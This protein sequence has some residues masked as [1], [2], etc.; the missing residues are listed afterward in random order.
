ML[1]KQEDCN[2]IGK[3]SLKSL[4][5]D[6]TYDSYDGVIIY[7]RIFEGELHIGQKIELHSNKKNYQVEKIGVNIPQKLLKNKLVAG[8]I[9]WFAANIRNMRDIKVGDTILN[10]QSTSNS[11]PGYQEI[12]PNVYANLY[13]SDSSSFKE[14]K[15]SLS[16]LQIQDSALVLEPIDSQLLGR[17]FNCG[18]LG[19]LHKDIICARLQKE[20]KCDVIVTI[21]SVIYQITDTKGKIWETNNPQNFPD[22][23]KI[24]DVKELFIFLTITTPKEFTGKIIELCQDKR[25]KQLSHEYKT[26][27]L[28]QL[29]YQLPFAEFIVDFH[30]KIKSISHGFASF[31]YCLAEFKSSTIVKVDILLNGQLIPDLSFLVHRKSAYERAK[32]FCKIIEQSLSRQ[33]FNI[34][35]QACIGKQVI[36]R[37]TISAFRKDVTSHLYGGDRTR[38]EKLWKKQILGKKKMQSLGK[39]SFDTI[40]FKK[41]LK[42]INS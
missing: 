37:E 41:F 10:Y 11:L 6:L 7:I 21:P 30:N 28:Y 1:S 33:N 38:K 4:V 27:D 34:P 40:N 13:P 25:G 16:E 20:Y 8:E 26:D 15:Q 35:I 12:K 32:N 19:L 18:F 9:G 39:V 42:N 5:F 29:V 2:E 36:A 24:K 22:N 23:N 31:K 17:G 3:E 14:F